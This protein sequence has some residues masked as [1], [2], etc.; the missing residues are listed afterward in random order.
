MA[1][2]LIGAIAKFQGQM[3]DYLLSDPAARLHFLIVPSKVKGMEHFG[4]LNIR[5]NLWPTIADKRSLK[6]F[7]R[8]LYHEM[9][10][11]V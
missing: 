6:F 3:T 1:E 9:T 4:L 2:A 5:E 8:T 7:A 10:H 11:Q